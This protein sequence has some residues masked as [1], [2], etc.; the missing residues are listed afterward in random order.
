MHLPV[1]IDSVHQIHSDQ[2]APYLDHN[3]K[4]ICEKCAFLHS[5]ICPCPMDYLSALVVEAVEAVDQRR[6]RDSGKVSPPTPPHG[7]LP[8]MQRAYQ[9]GAGT[10]GGCDWP[11]R[12]GQSGLE[13]QGCRASTARDMAAMSEGTLSEDWEAAALWLAQ[14]EANARRAEARA[15]AAVAAAE[16]GRWREA[17]QFAEQA[18][19][20]E[21]GSGRAIWR[22]PP[23]AWQKLLQAAEAAFLAHHLQ[24]TVPNVR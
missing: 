19:S 17:L 14:V 24:C 2:L 6:V 10:W 16:V 9:E 8:D 23:F 12:F 3:R 15:A 7:G 13:L 18:W 21:F 22:S 4:A 11:T 1:L 5:S 20:L